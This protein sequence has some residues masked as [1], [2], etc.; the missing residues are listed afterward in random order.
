VT[1]LLDKA[2]D[3]AEGVV[4]AIG[5][6]AAWTSVALVLL[7]AWNVLARYAL[8]LSTVASQEM[9]WH[10]LAVGALFGMSYGLAQGGE[11][12]VDVFYDRF[13]PRGQA[14]VD[15]LTAVLKT[16]IALIVVRLSASYVAQSYAIGEGSPDPG[17]LPHR[18]ILKAAIPV[19]FVLLAVQGAAM[20]LRALAR[21]ID[22]GRPP[23]HT[24]DETRDL[25]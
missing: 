2:A 7:V 23:A 20:T 22:G 21:L 15:L 16:A 17:G 25:A 5:H 10:L 14:A 8:G 19:A 18:W 12:R 6:A 13:G 4:R 1:R 24:I 9:E 11:V 3:G